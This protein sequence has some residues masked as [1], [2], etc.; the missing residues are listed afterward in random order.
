M[1]H[2]Y[3]CTSCHAEGYDFARHVCPAHVDP[4]P[5][6]TWEDYEPRAA[7]HAAAWRAR[8]ITTTT[9]TDTDNDQ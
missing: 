3:I 6:E 9:T 8:H 7:A 4:N 1:P 5:G 2:R